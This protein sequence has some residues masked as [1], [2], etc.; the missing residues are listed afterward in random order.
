MS[1]FANGGGT[2]E[3]SHLPGAFFEAA[4][5]LDNAEVLRNNSQPS[6]AP[7]QNISTTVD[8]ASKTVAIAATI[9]AGFAPNTSGQIT[10]IASD[11]LGSP[12]TNYDLGTGGTLKSTNVVGAFIEVAQLLSNGEK[13]VTPIEDQPNNVQV[14]VDAE[15][16][17]IT[18]S[19]TLPVT[20]D[21]S[22]G[23][24]VRIDA[25]DYL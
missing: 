18:V 3:S 9:P 25:I 24:G 12:W 22:S 15:S 2:F 14:V 8:F 11:Y 5:L 16:A 10:I 1:T 23:G 13:G 6:L 17:S 21:S 7:K 19:A 20:I 4:R